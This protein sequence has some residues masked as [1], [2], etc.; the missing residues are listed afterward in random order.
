MLVGKRAQRPI[1][2]GGLSGDGTHIW[3]ADLK[4][5]DK[6]LDDDGFGDIC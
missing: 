1:P 5:I 3:D 2:L 4:I 6:L